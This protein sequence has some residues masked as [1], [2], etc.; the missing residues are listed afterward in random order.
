MVAANAAVGR[1]WANQA[2]E[3]VGGVMGGLFCLVGVADLAGA[4]VFLPAPTHDLQEAL[5]GTIMVTGLAVAAVSARP[6]RVTLARFLPIDPGNPVH[7]LALALAVMLLGTDLAVISFTDVLKANQASPPLTISELLFSQ[8]PFIVFAF[9]GVGLWVRREVPASTG[10]L[11]LVVPRWWHVVLALA[12]AGLFLAAIIA[13]D[14]LDHALIPDVAR[15]VD[16][17]SNHVFGGLTDFWGIAAL[18]VVPALCEDLLF[19]GALQPRLGLVL[20]AVLFASTH[21]EYG[22]SFDTLGILALALGLGLIRKYANTTSSIVCHAAYNLLI[23]VGLGGVA[24]NVGIGVEAVL[25][26]VAG[27]ALWRHRPWRPAPSL[28]S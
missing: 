18:A 3:I 26:V 4:Q 28:E 9:A 24:M 17:T 12:A 10:R 16:Q 22:L 19:R 15:R 20:T 11:G 6:V 1:P 8:A 13:T 5:D 25:V 2:A 23:G 21:T 7:A 14:A 27:Y